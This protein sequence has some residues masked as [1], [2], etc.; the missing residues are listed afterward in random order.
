ME[1]NTSRVIRLQAW[2]RR[3]LDTDRQILVGHD[4]QSCRKCSAIDKALAAGGLNRAYPDRL[5]PVLQEIPR[6]GAW[7]CENREWVE[8]LAGVQSSK[9]TKHQEFCTALRGDHF[10]DASFDSLRV[11][12]GIISFLSPCV[13]P[14]VPGYVSMLFRH[15]RRNSSAR[16]SQRAT[17]CLLLRWRLSR[18]SPWCSS[19]SARRPA[20]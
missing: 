16:A 8:S 20:L 4:F 7:L 3:K 1:R 18:D 14:L 11:R 17:A 5:K 15:R 13:L 6:A 9:P 10:V 19:A 12:S 2:S